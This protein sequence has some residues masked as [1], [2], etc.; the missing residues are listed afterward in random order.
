M[1]DGDGWKRMTGESGMLDR[2]PLPS[3]GLMAFFLCVSSDKL[4]ENDLQFL[5]KCN[6]SFPGWVCPREIT[7]KIFSTT[8]YKLNY[9]TM[10]VGGVPSSRVCQR[11]INYLTILGNLTLVRS[12]VQ[13]IVL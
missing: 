7:H 11:L 9:I 6:V 5:T 2:N 4:G 1:L 3:R 12:S 13:S 8:Y 10:V